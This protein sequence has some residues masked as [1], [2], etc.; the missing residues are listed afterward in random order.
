MR[1][2]YT[3]LTQDGVDAWF[4]KENLLPGQDWEF[5]IRKAV[6]ETDLVVVCLS[7]NFNQAGFR[8]KEVRLALEVAME[9]PDGEIFIVPSKLEECEVIDSL[10]KW[11]WVDLFEDSGY[12]KLAQTLN[13]RAG[14]VDALFTR[15]S[16]DKLNISK[17]VGYPLVGQ[18]GILNNLASTY[19]HANDF[20]R[21]I[22]YYMKALV[23]S[24]EVG[25]RK[26]QAIIFSNLGSA[27]WKVKD[28]P[29][30]KEYFEQSLLFSRELGDRKAEV[31][32]LTNL[33]ST[34]ESVGD[35]VRAT[36]LYKMAFEINN[37]LEVALPSNPQIKNLERHVYENIVFTYQDMPS[38]TRSHGLRVMVEN[39]N[40][41]SVVCKAFLVKAFSPDESIN[42][43]LLSNN[44][45]WVDDSLSLV[46]ERK[47]EKNRV[48]TFFL[49]DIS[50]NNVNDEYLYF[51]MQEKVKK[52]VKRFRGVGKYRLT[53]EVQGAMDD[54]KFVCPIIDISFDVSLNDKGKRFI[55]TTQANIP[56]GV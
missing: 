55:R 48:G 31:S 37:M 35:L 10:R 5:E 23:L 42:K 45:Y 44:F 3:R 26:S 56:K 34:Y 36:E 12:E 18:V 41:Q 53:V 38:R 17:L 6:R 46:I 14:R 9:K 51:V 8:Q 29:K 16:E 49:A 30:A 13:L 50:T 28:F 54:I 11:H 39:K 27:Y 33:A 47:I 7:K 21:A 2:L 25:D 32:V 19:N 15:Q 40:S 1:G 24:E 52:L 20:E 43:Y 22:E 4:D